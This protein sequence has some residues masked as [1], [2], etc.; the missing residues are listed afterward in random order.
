MFQSRPP[1]PT[2]LLIKILLSTAIMTLFIGWSISSEASS[3]K[4]QQK[5]NAVSIT[6]SDRDLADLAQQTH[7]QVN[8]YR[9]SAN[10]SPLEFNAVISE[11]ARIHSENMAQQTV[12]FGHNGFENR[13]EALEDEIAYRG[14]AENVAYNMGHRDPVSKAVQGWIASDG[15]RQNMTGDYSLTGI[16]VAKNHRG[17]YY[18]TQIFIREQ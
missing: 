6:P 5:M 8:Q 1:L 17:E 13:V 14:V 9:A 11:Q 18:F 7:Q 16:G 12:K 15:H 10:L 2:P 3:Q 4:Y